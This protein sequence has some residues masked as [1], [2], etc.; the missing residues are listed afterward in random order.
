[1]Q[2][3]ALWFARIQPPSALADVMCLLLVTSAP[4]FSDQ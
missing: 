2:A 4:F 1:M 3:L